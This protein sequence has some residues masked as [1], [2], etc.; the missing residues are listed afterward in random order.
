MYYLTR[1]TAFEASHY[2]RIPELS[3]ADNFELFGAAANPNSHGHN[4]VLEVMVKGDVDANDGMVIN[5]TDLDALLKSEVN[6]N[7]DHKH[8]NSQHPVFSANPHLQPTCEN[9]TIDIWQRLVKSLT[10]GLLHRVRLYESSTAFADYYGEDRMVYHTKVYEFSAAHRLHSQVLTD[11]E[12][13]E[14]FGKCNNPAGHGHNYVLEVTVKGEVDEKTGLVVGLNLLDEVV[15]KQVYTR[16]DYKHLNLDIPEFETLNPT[17]ENF[18]KVLW[19]VLEPNLRPVVLHRL[20]LRETP[21]NHFDYYGE[22]S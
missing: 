9:I 19:D 5:L 17:S 15:A 12:N 13:Q 18:V 10:D 2:N 6:V 7:Y 8:L 1:Q 20:R 11:E 21:K 22:S 14:I 4:Y 16:F 3:D